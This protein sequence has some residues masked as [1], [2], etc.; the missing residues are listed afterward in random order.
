MNEKIWTEA[1]LASVK[2]PV[3]L[4]G[5]KIDNNIIVEFSKQQNDATWDYNVH[6]YSFNEK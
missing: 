3:T 6:T 2:D 1:L 5:K 4:I